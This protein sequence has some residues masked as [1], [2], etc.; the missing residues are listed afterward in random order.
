MTEPA[1]TIDDA[2][3]PAIIPP[4]RP[5]TLTPLPDGQLIP[6]L[7]ADAGDQAS[8]R[9]IDYFT[10][11][12]RNPNTRRAYARACQTFFAWCDERGLI[13]ATI[14]PYDVATY[15][16]TRCL[17]HSAPDVKQ[18]LAAVRML[19]D[20]LVT[21][22][23]VPHNPAAAVR[24]PKHVVKTGKTPV[25]DGKEWRT[26][27]DSIPSET[28]R[29]LRDRALIATLT[30]SFARIG[31]ALKMRVE[32]LR[33]KGAGWE[34]RL[35]EKGGKHHVMPC[36]HS[37]AEELRAYI[38]TAGIA[39]DSKGYLFRTSKGHHG[40]GLS[41]QP[42]TQPDAWRMIRKRAAVVGI[43]AP[44]GNHSFRATGIT[45]YLSNGGA[46]EHAQEMAAHESP[47]TTRLYDRTKERLTQDEVERIRL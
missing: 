34:L 46:L 31:A 27:L 25:L 24:G 18:Q 47:R 35:H 1:D 40:V 30:Y 44:I 11:N 33:P 29:D 36:H 7:I 39:E 8:W 43:F 10:S 13:L 22:Q 6:A 19:F 32:D 4:G 12:I 14:R 5:V 45:A 23:V 2:N 9:Y 16:E 28:V 17:T 26:L 15:I 41:K 21:G 20:W 3:L 37:L 42:M 38:D